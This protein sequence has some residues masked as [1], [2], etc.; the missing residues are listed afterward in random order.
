MDGFPGLGIVDWYQCHPIEL[1]IRLVAEA[2]CFI[3]RPSHPVAAL[4]ESV[5]VV[6][7]MVD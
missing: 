5:F 7:S 1:R 6:A 2:S 3:S 4:T